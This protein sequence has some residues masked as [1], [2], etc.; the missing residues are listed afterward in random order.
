MK[1]EYFDQIKAGT[2]TEEYRLCTPY[3]CRRLVGRTFDQIELSRG[4]AARNGTLENFL[5]LPWRGHKFKT[6]THPHFGPKPVVV[7]AINVSPGD[8]RRD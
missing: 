4:Y 5:T 6:I 1:G 2:K 7:F 8:T 3:W